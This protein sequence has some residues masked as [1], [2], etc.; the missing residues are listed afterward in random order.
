MQINSQNTIPIQLEFPNLRKV[1][2]INMNVRTSIKQH[3]PLFGNKFDADFS[4]FQVNACVKL[5]K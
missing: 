1:I 3:L 4:S 5:N 2:K